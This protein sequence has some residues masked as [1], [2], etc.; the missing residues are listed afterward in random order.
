MSTDALVFEPQVYPNKSI[1]FLSNEL[2]V[3]DQRVLTREL[4]P[5]MLGS[6]FTFT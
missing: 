5:N 4:E 2:E 6:T 3:S 1:F